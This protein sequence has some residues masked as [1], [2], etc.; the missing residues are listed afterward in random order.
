VPVVVLPQV[1]DTA[2]LFFEPHEIL[3]SPLLYSAEVF[4]HSSF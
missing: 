4:Q 1:Q 2:L 3:V